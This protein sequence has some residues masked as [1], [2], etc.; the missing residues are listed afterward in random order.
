MPAFENQLLKCDFAIEKIQNFKYRF[1]ESRV[2][3]MTKC[4]TN[5]HVHNNNMYNVINSLKEMAIINETEE[6]K[7]LLF[8]L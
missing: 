6:R 2:F 7:S 1:E 3:F 4:L 5:I 8:I